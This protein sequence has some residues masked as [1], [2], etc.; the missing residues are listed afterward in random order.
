MHHLS[1]TVF[2]VPLSWSLFCRV[3]NISA[4]PEP[5]G[6]PRI[7]IL[8]PKAGK[9]GQLGHST[10]FIFSS[11]SVSLSFSPHLSQVL[12]ILLM[13]K[14]LFYTQHLV[15]AWPAMISQGGGIWKVQADQRQRSS[16]LRDHRAAQ[17]R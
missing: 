14:C 9:P 8:R 3:T 16:C 10:S 4:F 5:A 1:V 17:S 13:P 7:W 11:L 12:L 6:F 2:S 15:C